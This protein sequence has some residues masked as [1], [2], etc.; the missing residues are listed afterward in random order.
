MMNLFMLLEG[1]LEYSGF[2][3]LW[4]LGLNYHS[5]HY[6]TTYSGYNY[7]GAWDMFKFIVDGFIDDM[8][9]TPMLGIMVVAGVAFVIGV[10]DALLLVKVINMIKNY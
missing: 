9:Y 1:I 7:T 5:T 2:D 6:N 10:I 4:D 3:L 8:L